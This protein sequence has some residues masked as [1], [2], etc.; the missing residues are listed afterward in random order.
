MV[1]SI[2]A[3]LRRGRLKLGGKAVPLKAALFIGMKGIKGI[4]LKNMVHPV[5]AYLDSWRK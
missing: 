5:N 2:T 1:K 4:K 3:G